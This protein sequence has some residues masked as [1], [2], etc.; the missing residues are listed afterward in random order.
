VI[1]GR[2]VFLLTEQG[3]EALPVTPDAPIR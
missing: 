1:E 3:R 2:T